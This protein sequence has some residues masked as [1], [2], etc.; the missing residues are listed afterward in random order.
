MLYVKV[1]L[2]GF[3]QIGQPAPLPKDLVGLD[4]LT[5]SDMSWF[6][7]AYGPYG[8]WPV[9]V[10]DP[11]PI[12]MGTM[13]GETVSNIVL[14]IETK[15][16]TA[17]RNLVPQTDNEPRR[18]TKIVFSRLFT[19]Q[20]RAILNAAKATIRGMTPNDYGNPFLM[21][22]VAL[23]LIMDAF[24]L[25]AEYIELNHPDTILAIGTVFVQA[26]IL[27]KARSEQILNNLMPDGSPAI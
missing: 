21:P 22:I 24:E 27:T 26:G 7:G 19:F 3:V 8:F 5:L 13:L 6:D 15:T 4:D 25:P 23:E 14:N 17:R 2:D 9:E 16:A 18:V 20:E 1:L 11:H 12:P 10:Y